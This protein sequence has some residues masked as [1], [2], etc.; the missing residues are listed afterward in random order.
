MIG[1]F[2]IAPK[3]AAEGYFVGILTAAPGF[4][5]KIGQ[6]VCWRGGRMLPG[7]LNLDAIKGGKPQ[8]GR[9]DRYAVV[10]MQI[11]WQLVR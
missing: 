10:V 1:S 11:D 3:E 2:L 6:Q 8:G 4:G 9:V 5:Q 7:H